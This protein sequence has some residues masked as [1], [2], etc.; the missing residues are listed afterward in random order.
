MKNVLVV[1][2]DEKICWAF[3]Q[4]LE[5]EGFFPSIANNAEEGLRKIQAEQPDVI[6]LDVR[7][8]GMSGLDALEQIKELQSNAVVVIMTAYDDV[9]TTI[10]AMRLQAFDFLPKPIDLDAVKAVL[11]RASKTQAERRKIA[12]GTTSDVASSVDPSVDRAGGQGHRLVGKSEQ[13]RETY[14]LIG[15]MASNTITV[16]IEGDTGTGKELVAQAIHANSSRKDGPFISVNC[17]ALPDELLESELFGYEAGAF[18]GAKAKGKPGRF[19][20]ADGGTLFLDEVSN[21]SPALQ[22]K[23]QRALQEQEIES[24]GGTRTLKTNVRV[25]AAT[26]QDLAEMARLGLFRQDL[27]YRF[28]RLAVH[29]P[30]LRERTEDITLLVDHFLNLISAELGKTIT[31]VSDDCLGLL[32]R[33]DWPGNVRELVNALRSAAVLSRSDVVLP[34][35]LPPD[36]V[37]YEPKTELNQALLEQS[38]ES[39]LQATVK[40]ALSQEREMLYDEVIN[41]VDSALIRLTINKFGQNQ[42][43]TAKLLGISRTTLAQRI[44][45][46]GLDLG[47]S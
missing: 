11:N 14:K 33:Y 10:E 41:A 9:E 25:L 32:A 4:F 45:K 5:S 27:Y 13:M 31:G 44:K 17:G 6:F 18:T 39:I 40:E 2:D 47:N 37:N 8:P 15:V 43:E 23:L 30:P 34:E 28:K 46:L 26:N 38:L 24:L 35:H 3:E 20:L 19:E 42:T 12:D 16:L 21:M 1:D 36:I 29:L 7:L 22:I